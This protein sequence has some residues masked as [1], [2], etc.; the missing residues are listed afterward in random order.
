[1]PEVIFYYIYS[2]LYS[3]SY[4]TRYVAFLKTDFPRVPFTANH[5]LFI[6]MGKLGKHLVDI[7]ILEASGL[8]HPV[9]HFEG[10]GDNRVEKQRYIEHEQRVYINEAQY[11]ERIAKENYE[12]Q[13]GGYQVL[14]K[15]LKDRK[16]RLLSLEDIQHYCRIATVIQKTIEI[17]AKIDGLYPAIEQDVLPLTL[18]K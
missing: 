16:G 13:I 10:K 9:A 18:A 8:E 17:Q 5:K 11:F 4:R 1:M 3:D 14:D 6:E 12:H 7:H 15:W 2:V